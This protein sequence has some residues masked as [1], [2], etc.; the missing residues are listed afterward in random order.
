LTIL[1]GVTLLAVAIRMKRDHSVAGLCSQSTLP[2]NIRL[3]IACQSMAGCFLVGLTVCVLA[4][5]S[6]GLLVLCCQ[7]IDSVFVVGDGGGGC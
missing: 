7:I 5:G 6:D 2:P 4:F 3:L 1:R